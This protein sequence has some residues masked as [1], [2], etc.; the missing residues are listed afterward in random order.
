[1]TISSYF[2]LLWVGARLYLVPQSSSYSSVVPGVAAR[3]SV[4]GLVI[5]PAIVP[6]SWCRCLGITGDMKPSQSHCGC[7]NPSPRRG[8]C[9]SYLR[10]TNSA[11]GG[12]TPP[13]S[14]ERPN[15]AVSHRTRV[16]DLQCA[17]DIF[18]CS[19]GTVCPEVINVSC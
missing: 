6:G 18:R 13:P 19:L 4:S 15:W 12:F 9:R 14:S 10:G 11:A 3:T 2:L 5:L 7:G 8:V 1:M 17:L 16:A